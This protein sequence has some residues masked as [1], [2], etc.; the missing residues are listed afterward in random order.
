[1]VNKKS[2]STSSRGLSVRVKTAKGRKV[3]STRWLQRQ[4]NDPYVE[5]ARS[6]GYAS[7]AA[8][9]LLEIDEKYPILEQS[10]KVIDLGSAPGSWSQ[11][12]AKKVNLEDI[13]AVDLLEMKAVPRVNFIQ[14]DFRDEPIQTEIIELL[15]G[16]K[17]DLILSDMAPNMLGHKQTD[18]L[19]VIAL[20]EEVIF[21]A[22]HHLKDGGNMAIKAFHGGQFSDMI[23]Q[24]KEMFEKVVLFKPKASRSDSSEMYMICLGFNK[25]SS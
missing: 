8:Y 10:K 14:G 23:H 17:L 1:M 5:M 7:R 11:V 20:C 3:S 16:G 25:Q 4:L 19:R 9:K 24:C 2:Q 21:F 22:A 6:D 15:K 18:H 13:I 12:L